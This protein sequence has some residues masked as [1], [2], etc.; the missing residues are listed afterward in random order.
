MSRPVPLAAS[1]Q[2]ESARLAAACTAC[3]A[4]VEACPMPDFVGLAPAAPAAVAAGMRAA[5]QGAPVSPEGLAWVGA[6][7]RSGQCNAACPEALDVALM[8]RLAGMRLKGA[9]GEPAR[10]P[11]PGDAGWAARVKAFARMTLTEEEQ[12]RWL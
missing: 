11:V 12:A 7:T 3:G 9:L 2:A 4:C 8:L 1:I 6:C 5:L 10:L